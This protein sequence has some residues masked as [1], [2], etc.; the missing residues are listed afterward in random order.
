MRIAVLI[1]CHKN[2]KQIEMLIDALNSNEVDFYI[3]IDK[4]AKFNLDFGMDNIVILSESE[5]VDVSWGGYTMIE[6]TLAL[7][8]AMKRG[9]N[10]YQYAW[11]IS[12]QDFPLRSIESILDFFK[13]NK[14]RDYIEILTDTEA[15]AKNYPKRNDLIYPNW[16]YKNNIMAKVLKRL[17]WI[18][19]GGKNTF[20]FKR[21]LPK[22][23]EKF[24]F[25]S[26]WW[27]LTINSLDKIICFLK[28]NPDIFEFYQSTLVPDECFFQ[29][30]YMATSNGENRENGLCFVNWGKNKCSPECFLE[31]DF[32][33]LSKKSEKYL[34]ARKFDI[35][36]DSK[37]I[38]KLKI[39]A[40]FG[41]KTDGS[42]NSSNVYI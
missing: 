12:G 22:S 8:K 23:I 38:D 3:H 6:A 37:I 21:K 24:Y 18:F 25:G 14:N 16:M 17:Y 28:D 35:N 33:S 10:N 34:I 4:K 27:A 26:Q 1:L 40:E 20:I 19:T 41:D 29:T 15:Y 42:S 9:G 2:P 36:V 39:F 7:I 13:E 32:E 31:T 11:L 5:S 30:L